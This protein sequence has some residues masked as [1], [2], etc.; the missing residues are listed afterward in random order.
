MSALVFVYIYTFLRR[1]IWFIC[2]YYQ[3]NLV[4]ATLFLII[5]AKFPAWEGINW[6]P[7]KAKLNKPTVPHLWWSNKSFAISGAY[8]YHIVQALTIRGY[9]Q[10]LNLF[11]APY[12]FQKGPSKWI[13]KWKIITFLCKNESDFFILVRI[14]YKYYSFLGS[15][16]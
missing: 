7:L 9:R 12:D 2:C 14:K 11:G 10:E 15:K 16:D 4:V 1:K 6:K 8:F 3:L 13:G 5:Y